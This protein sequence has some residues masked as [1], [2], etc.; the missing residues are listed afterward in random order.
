M[1]SGGRMNGFSI[2][3]L[4]QSNYKIWKSI[5]KR[6]ISHNLFDHIVNGK[7]ACDIWTTL[8]GLFNKKD[9]LCSE[10]S[11]LDLEDPISEARLKRRIICGLKRE[12]TPYVTSTQGWVEQPFLVEFENILTSQESLARQIARFSISES[13][14]DALFTSNNKYSHKEKDKSKGSNDHD[15]EKSSG[16]GDGNRKYVKCYRCG[17][18]RHIKRTAVL[19]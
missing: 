6:S 14:R 7:S 9:N 1:N 17:K 5:L 19:N 18:L 3:L 2:E 8:D 13:D 4:N 15:D 16:K 10:I 12:Y 11:L